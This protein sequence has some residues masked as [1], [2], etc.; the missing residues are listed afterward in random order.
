M[1]GFGHRIRRLGLD[2]RPNGQDLCSFT[3]KSASCGRGLRRRTHV[4]QDGETAPGDL[5]HYLPMDRGFLGW[6]NSLNCGPSFH[7]G[8]N[9]HWTARQQQWHW[10]MTRGSRACWMPYSPNCSIR[11]LKKKNSRDSWTGNQLKKW[12]LRVIRNWTMLSYALTFE[13]EVS[14]CVSFTCLQLNKAGRYC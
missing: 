8:R 13:L 10:L 4:H 2:G 1:C 7:E 14:D 12:A 5:R 11:T 6:Y 9:N 3:K